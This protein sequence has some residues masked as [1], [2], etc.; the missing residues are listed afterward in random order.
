M[1]TLVFCVSSAHFK[2]CVGYWSEWQRLVIM[3]VQQILGLD[4]FLCKKSSACLP[5]K[6]KLNNLSHAPNLRHAKEP[7]N[8]GE[9]RVVSEIPSKQFPPLLAEGSRTTWCDGASGDEGGNYYIRGRV[10][11]T[12]KKS[13][14]AEDPAKRPLTLC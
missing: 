8:C 10:Q 5:L 9:L 7:S 2:P 13:C 3:C 1:I 12:K 11:S 4:F 14:S 6:G